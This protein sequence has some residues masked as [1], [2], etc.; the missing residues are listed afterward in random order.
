M[1]KRR[2]Y[3]AEFKQGAVEQA[4]QAN[5][6]I[7]QV[8]IE[9]GINANMLARWVRES[10]SS[11]DSFTG[12]GSP[13]D[14]ELAKLKRELARLLREHGQHLAAEVEAVAGL[15]ATTKRD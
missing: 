3:T 6:T 4:N 13:R 8:A 14:A 15:V 1:S 5:V 9:L 12:T 2:K 11:S 10:E 7:R